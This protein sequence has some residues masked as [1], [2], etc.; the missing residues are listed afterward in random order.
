V[1]EVNLLIV[2][3]AIPEEFVEFRPDSGITIDY[4]ITSFMEFFPKRELGE[5]WMQVFQNSV[6]LALNLIEYDTA[7]PEG[8]RESDDGEVSLRFFNTEELS[9][10]L[11][12][13]KSKLENLLHWVLA[14]NPD[15]QAFVMY[16]PTDGYLVS[17]FL[18]NQLRKT[19]LKFDKFLKRIASGA[20]KFAVT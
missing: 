20:T 3:G 18:L 19:G 7:P 13:N 2:L 14:Q 15:L 16:D 5:N 6:R 1:R 11:N 12:M 8:V 9:R 17:S 10:L 4:F